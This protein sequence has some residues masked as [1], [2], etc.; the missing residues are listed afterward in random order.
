MKNAFRIALLQTV[1][2]C[3]VLLHN[4]NGMAQQNLSPEAVYSST[5]Q[6]IK[7]FKKGDQVIF[8]VIRLGNVEQF[9]MHFD[10]LQNSPKNYF[11]T[12]I[13]CN[14]DWSRT[15]LS[16]MDYVKGYTQNRINQYRASSAT[17]TRYFHYTAM[18]PDKNCMPS[19]SGNYL[20]LVFQ[21]GDTSKVIFSR[22][23]LVVDEKATVAAE[24]RQP[25]NQNFFQSHQK[26]VTKVDI[27]ALDVYNPAQQLKVVVMQNHRWDMVQEGSNP[28]FIRGKIYE[29]SAEDRF[30]FEAGKEWRW[31]DLRSL[32]LQSDRVASVNYNP[33][34]YDVFVRPDTVRSSM[35]Y[36]Y[37]NDLN[38][39]Y[40]IENMENVNPWWQSDYAN[41]H[42]TFLPDDPGM[43]K[44]QRIYVYGELTNFE[45][46]KDFA[47]EW[48]ENLNVFEKTLLLKNGYYSYIYVTQSINNPKELPRVMLTEGSNWEAENQYSIMVYYRPFGGRADELVGYT[49]INSLNFLSPNLR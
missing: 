42:F 1:T 21:N 22:R 35:R 36:I 16:Q 10:D 27:R 13:L 9:E 28:T 12:Y 17:F 41:V 37:Y 26:I 6:S 47:M 39:R 18:L 11:Y 38:G 43:Y 15:N 33:S 24:A 45:L 31:L 5:I 8:P 25:F 34:S 48:N 32:R 14:A 30:V 4:I 49:E 23:F 20:L 29:Y 44:N 7:L 40:F 46:R 19:R 3:W 2:F